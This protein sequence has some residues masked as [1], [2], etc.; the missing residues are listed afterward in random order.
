MGKSQSKRDVSASPQHDKQDSNCHSEHCEESHLIDSYRDSSVSTKLQ[1][2]KDKD[3]NFIPTGM[4]K[5]GRELRSCQPLT[6]NMINLD[7]HEMF[8]SMGIY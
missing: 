3:S 1:N 8:I 6:L 2:D 5:Y 7:S 4:C